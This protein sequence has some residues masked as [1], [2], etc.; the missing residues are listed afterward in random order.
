MIFFRENCLK[1]FYG[2]GA[3]WLSYSIISMKMR[4]QNMT[5]GYWRNVQVLV[6]KQ[7]YEARLFLYSVF[8][9]ILQRQNI[10][11]EKHI[12]NIVCHLQIV[13]D[14]LRFHLHLFL[15]LSFQ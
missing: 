10:G 11:C 3:L 15:E 9:E 14:H 13:K 1:T 12:L 2:I 4:K 8:E 6:Q 5:N 7:I